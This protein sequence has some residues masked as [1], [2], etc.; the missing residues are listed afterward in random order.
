MKAHFLYPCIANSLFI[1]FSMIKVYFLLKSHKDNSFHRFH[2]FSKM[3]TSG[4]FMG[5]DHVLLLS[6]CSAF[7][8]GEQELEI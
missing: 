5:L 6:L 2:D 7:P 3:S 1:F 8:S 4:M